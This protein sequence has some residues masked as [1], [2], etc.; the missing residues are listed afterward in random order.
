MV[1]DVDTGGEIASPRGIVGD[2]QK[3]VLYWTDT[4]TSL[5][6]IVTFVTGILFTRQ[7]VG[8]SAQLLLWLNEKTFRMSEW[9]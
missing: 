7:F 1:E 5:A 4:S 6:F 8:C 2:W 3:Q 9:S